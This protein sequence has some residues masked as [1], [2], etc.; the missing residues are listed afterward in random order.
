[1]IA[2]SGALLKEE[3]QT[4]QWARGALSTTC[5]MG[6]NFRECQQ[7]LCNNEP[8]P[9]RA[10]TPLISITAWHSWMKN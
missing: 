3:A 9:Q 2:F 8:V 6:T 7:P 4:P 1:M 5:I 10:E